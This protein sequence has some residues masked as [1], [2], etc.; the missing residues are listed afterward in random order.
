VRRK[1]VEAKAQPLPVTSCEGALSATLTINLLGRPAVLLDG[2]ELRGFVSV[3][4]EALLCYLAAT[5]RE[6]RREFLAGQLWA[7]SSEEQALKNLR[8]VLSNL[9]RLL[10]SYD[11][12]LITRQSVGLDPGGYQLDCRQFRELLAEAERAGSPE[13]ASRALREAVALYRG[14][15]LEGVYLA[16]APDFEE[17]ALAEREQLRQLIQHALH[18]LAAHSAETGNYGE[19]I[20]YATRLLAMDPWL[21]EAHRQ[22]MLLLALGGQRSAALAQ[23]A[24]CRRTLRDELGVDPADETTALYERILAGEVTGAAPALA[25]ARARHNLTAALAPLIGRDDEAAGLLGRLRD[26]QCRL[27]SLIGPGGVGKTC[28]AQHVAQRLLTAQQQ[29]DAFVHGIYFVSLAAIDESA[30]ADA[31]DQTRAMYDT[32]AARVAAML[33]LSLSGPTAPH[34]QLVRFLHDKELLLI[35]DN[36]EH[37]PTLAD[38]VVELLQQAPGLTLLATSRSRLNVGGEQVVELGGLDFPTSATAADVWERYP[39]LRLFRERALAARA[40][41]SFDDLSGVE[42]A[43]ICALLD[44]LP[45]AIELAASLVRLL[46]CKDIA[47][48]LA[49]GVEVLQST[50]RDIPARHRSLRAVF[51]HSWNLLPAAEQQALRTLSVFR[52]DFGREAAQ[53]VAGVALPQLGVLAD[54]S[55]LRVVA[56]A[57]QGF[58][59]RYLLLEV[60]RQ[61]AAERL[62]EA[63]D[64]QATVRD[65]HSRYFLAF[66][67]A[68]GRELRGPR[69]QEA[70]GQINRELENIRDAWRWAVGRGELGGLAAAADGLF[71]FYEMRSWFGEGAEL[72]A[73][74]SARAEELAGTTPGAQTSLV[75]GRLLARQGWL[76]FHLGH[77]TAARSL[78]ARSLALIRPLGRAAEL[79]FS[80]NRLAAAVYYAGDYAQAEQLAAEALAVSLAEG[81]R[82]GEIVART[83]LG[84]IAYLVGRYEDARRYGYESL[85]LERELGN[86]WGTVFTLINLGRTASALGEYAEARRHFEEGLAIREMLRD[87]R[88]IALCLNHLGDTAAALGDF[89]EAGRR[90]EASLGLYREIGHLEGAAASL[91]RLGRNSLALSRGDAAMGAFREALAIARQAR[92]TPQQLDALAGIAAAQAGDDPVRAVELAAL[93][94]QHPSAT[95]ESRDRAGALLSQLQ[96][97]ADTQSVGAGRGEQPPGEIQQIVDAILARA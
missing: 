37:L 51:D 12:L 70:L 75:L 5:G 60:V 7:E 47:A 15:F 89:A 38:W 83:V 79:A 23:Y 34:V 50:R 80:L 22:L 10:A 48:E 11:G 26:P 85:A 57:E 49:A 76:T 13:S 39:A 92:S 77:P 17:W 97:G 35:L 9:R 58:S 8:D 69:Q 32:L 46:S 25:A 4:A 31:A 20:A 14:D 28:L 67:D 87:T 54:N 40:Q 61:Y 19:G 30:W 44:G 18:R 95:R 93:V 55:L 43:R 62:A 52:G 68:Q 73:L 94:A 78:L 45:L 63:A 88:G 84:Q 21:E 16:Q 24:A 41:L 81:D 72:F 96:N 65:R 3:K 56:P 91:S 1:R 42:A 90:Y 6:H 86:I 66:A 82:D 33:E 53:Q 29:G 71:Y 27:L 36:C 59:G 2:T 64:E 74:A